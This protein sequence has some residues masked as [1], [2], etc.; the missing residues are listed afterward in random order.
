MHAAER[1]MLV[2]GPD[3]ATFPI[4]FRVPEPAIITV[5]GEIILKGG[6]KNAESNVNSAPCRVNRN[7]AHNLKYWAENLWAISCNKNDMVKATVSPRRTI[8][9]AFVMLRK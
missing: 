1:P 4:I 5:P 6:G 3:T 9:E 2:I 8:V 7:S